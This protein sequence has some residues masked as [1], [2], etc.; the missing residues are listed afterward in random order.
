MYSNQHAKRL[1][2]LQQESAQLGARLEQLNAEISW[3]ERFDHETSHARLNQVQRDMLALHLQRV[4]VEEGIQANRAQ[5]S[6]AEGVAVAGWS[7]L[8]WFSSERSV[9]KRQVDTAGQRLQQFQSRQQGLL[10]EIASLEQ[11]EQRL[12][13]DLQ[14]HRGFDPLQSRASATLIEQERQRLQGVLDDT[15]QA[16]Q[17]WEAAAGK[18]YRYWKEARDQLLSVEQG[19]AEAQCFVHEL[20]CAGN[21]YER[22]NVHMACESRF[23]QGSPDQALRDLQGNQ[24]KL[25]K[26]EEK[27]NRRL[28]DIIR[29]LDN[30]I[31][32][33]VIDGNNLCYRNEEGGKRRF[34]GLAALKPM[35]AGLAGRYGITL[36]F[37]PGIRSLLQLD[38]EAL[39]AAF[40]QASVLVMPR[41]VSADHPV[42][43]A[44]EFNAGTFVLSNDHYDDYPEMAAVREQRILHVIL[45]KDGVQIPQLQELM[46]Y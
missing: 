31:R 5:L 13:A 29:V 37:D 34:I 19:I 11:L 33:L 35:V 40:P 30:D 9:A 20:S 10:A 12:G 36:M 2:V 26:E 6:Q 42:L 28:R 22:R 8:H 1:L 17:R 7:P 4:E 39:Q 45:H 32:D 41:S 43:A 38:D 27:L 3:F 23:G 16:S 21:S 46:A 18:V 15:H 14:R 44:A 24:R 25:V